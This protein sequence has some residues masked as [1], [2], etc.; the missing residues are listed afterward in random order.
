MKQKAAAV[1]GSIVLW[2]GLVSAESYERSVRIV[3]RPSNVEEAYV[4]LEVLGVPIGIPVFGSL[5]AVL[6]AGAFFGELDNTDFIVAWLVG[7][8]AGVILLVMFP[9]LMQL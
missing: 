3:A 7:I 4:L 2:L 6:F 5:F 1:L 8:F 9:L